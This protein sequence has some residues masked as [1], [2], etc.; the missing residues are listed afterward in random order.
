M[1]KTIILILALISV[2]IVNAIVLN[3]P[4]EN[5]VFGT[6]TGLL[7]ATNDIVGNANVSFFA[8]IEDNFNSSHLTC[9]YENV[10]LDTES[11]CNTT[12]VR[13]ELLD[14]NLV[15]YYKFD[16]DDPTGDS[17]GSNDLTEQGSIVHK[18][19]K[20]VIMDAYL[21]D[22]INDYLTGGN[23]IDNDGFTA[24]GWVKTV[25]ATDMKVLHIG[26]SGPLTVSAGLFRM[27]VDA[28][29]CQPCNPRIDDGEWHFI[30]AVVST[31]ESS[32]YI[33]GVF[34]RTDFDNPVA[35]NGNVRIGRHDTSTQ[36]FNGFIDEIRVYDN[37]L[38]AEE[39]NNLYQFG[40]GKYY[41]KANATNGTDTSESSTRVFNKDFFSPVILLNIAIGRKLNPTK[42]IN[43]TSEDAFNTSLNI[44]IDGVQIFNVSA[45]NT[46]QTFFDTLPTLSIG[47]HTMNVTATD[48]H[49]LSSNLV[50]DFFVSSGQVI[51]KQ[52]SAKNITWRYYTPFNISLRWFI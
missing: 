23:I 17:K 27:C 36:F 3:S 42:I 14:S 20:G 37:L 4:P 33:D 19:N 51:I 46:F 50:R 40:E 31:T 41:W 43:I 25:I 49:D 38:T 1:K 2:V 15:V 10:A 26:A 47:L 11:V 30:V 52:N 44:S 28:S 7:N 16:R 9:L 5:G 24:T 22:G 32:C 29:S 13:N 21:F 45:N 6:M 48:I 18:E 35:I 8:S 12:A 34:D 39:I